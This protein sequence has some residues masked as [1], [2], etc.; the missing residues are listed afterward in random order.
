MKNLKT[1]LCITLSCVLAAGLLLPS[2]SAKYAPKAS[3]APA[4]SSTEID[5]FFS[6]DRFSDAAVNEFLQLFP[7]F[8]SQILF[9]FHNGEPKETAVSAASHS[10][11]GTVF[12]D[13]ELGTMTISGFFADHG[14]AVFPDALGA[15]LMDN[16]FSSVGAAMKTADSWDDLR[17]TD[18]SFAFDWGLD[19]TENLTERYEAFLSVIGT[20]I[21]AARPLFNAAFGEANAE[22][23]FTSGQTCFR[24]TVVDVH[25]EK[26][27]DSGETIVVTKPDS[28]ST[29]EKGTITFE[30]QD[31]YRLV[32]IPVYQAFGLGSAVACDFADYDPDCD[33]TDLAGTLY[34]PL[35]TLVSAVQGD[36]QLYD[37]L[38]AYYRS[39]AG[40]AAREA[41]GTGLKETYAGSLKIDDMD[42]KN[43]DS[44][45]VGNL[46]DWFWDVCSEA[47]LRQCLNQTIYFAP[48]DIINAGAVKNALNTLLPALT[49][50]APE[51][52]SEPATQPETPTEPAT[53]PTTEAQED[54]GSGNPF[55]E[56]LKSI[57][58]FFRRLV[59]WLKS[60]FQFS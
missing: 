58:N 32:V 30:A 10:G 45:A 46:S 55:L 5:A 19:A 60:L 28:M 39:D 2:L 57:S 40:A 1:I 41:I 3:V 31:L 23:K 27:D 18:G 15:Y 54:E 53:E 16:G 51:E 13:G 38:I 48:T 7:R 17:E 33:A 59:E 21:N 9:F 52:P 42:V 44:S 49:V 11:T 6:A 47:M 24:A 35:Y 50:P 56:F 12:Y 8:C 36:E 25:T 20:L 26:T 37:E 22:I 29:A 43:I 4:S 14:V 34:A